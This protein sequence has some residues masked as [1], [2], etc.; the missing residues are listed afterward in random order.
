[1]KEINDGEVE[2]A[3]TFLFEDV[4]PQ[5]AFRLSESARKIPLEISKLIP[6]LHREGINCRHL[7]WVRYWASNTDVR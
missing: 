2:D 7:G 1:M 4:I 6:A 5:F 3:T